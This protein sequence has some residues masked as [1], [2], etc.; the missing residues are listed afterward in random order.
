[1]GTNGLHGLRIAHLIETDGPGGAERMVADLATELQRAGAQT[2]VVLPADREGWLSRQLAD[3]GVAIEYFRL[4]RPLSF[5]FARWLTSV[6][7]RHRVAIAHSHEF[8]MAVYGGW[9]AWRARIPHTITMHGNHYYAKRLRRR[10]ALRASV[11]LGSRM[12]AV[13]EEL[14]RHLGRDLWLATSRINTI[15]NG[16]RPAHVANSTLREELRLAPEDRVLLAIGNLYPVK[17]HRY[18]VEA[19]ALLRERDP[20]LHL[21]IA[22]RGELDDALRKQAEALGVVDRLHLLGLRSDIPNLLAAADVFVLPSLSEG[23]P[24][25]LLEAMFAGRPIVA[26]DVG[27]IRNVLANGDAGMLVPAG[28]APGLAAALATLL[29]APTHAQELASRARH[30]AQ[31]EYDVSRMVGRYAEVYDG[32]LSPRRHATTALTHLPLADHCSAG[33]RVAPR[34]RVLSNSDWF[35]GKAESGVPIEARHTSRSGLLGTLREFW[36]ARDCDAVV[37]NMASRQL[38]LFCLLRKLLP[39]GPRKLVAVDLMLPRPQGI[40]QRV[41]AWI[42]RR[43][44]KAVDLFIFYFRD[45]APWKRFYGIAPDRTCYVPFKVNDYQR[46]LATTTRDEGFI[47]ACGRTHRDYATFFHAVRGLPIEARILARRHELAENGT[48]DDVGSLCAANIT[49]VEDDGSSAS[50]IDWIARSRLVVLPLSP[51]T[52]FA[53]GISTYLVAMALGKCVIITEG[54]ATR[55]MLEDGQAIIVPP[56]DPEALRAAIMAASTDVGYRTRV[57]AAGQRY[58]RALGD[59]K[60]LAMDITCEVVRLVAQSKARRGRR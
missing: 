27:E 2:L 36:T 26:S 56:S 3:S 39:I 50:W 20:K 43:L 5:A 30:R 28:D 24:L 7:R 32:L 18:A 11:S 60:R 44:L 6:F 10:L 59:H 40:R 8:T 21:L 4:D 22:G 53:A 17:G 54:T 49:V 41:R 25:A 34:L 33:S 13:S 19:L 52:P 35:D 47:L 16:V 14:R 31:L 48:Q 46:V 58:A 42:V 37:F 1:V 55:G 15:P 38:L 23:L 9:A 45:I 57:G 51:G 29:E 12:V